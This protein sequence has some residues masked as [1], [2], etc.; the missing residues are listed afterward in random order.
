MG[1]GELQRARTGEAG[2]PSW[3]LEQIVSA[4]DP[5]VHEHKVNA[6]TSVDTQD[7]PLMDS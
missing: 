1:V 4:L 2:I 6:K 3:Q 7:R 5:G